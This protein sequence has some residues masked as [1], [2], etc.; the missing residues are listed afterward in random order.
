MSR[1]LICTANPELARQ[2][3]GIA[4]QAGLAVSQAARAPLA[5]KLMT[6]HQPELVLLDDQFEQNHAL[7]A[8]ANLLGLHGR[9]RIVLLL[10]QG[11]FELTRAALRLGIADMVLVPGEMDRLADLLGRLRHSAATR[12]SHTE[13]RC[14]AFFAAKGGAGCTTLAINTAVAC[15]GLLSGPVLLLDGNMQTGDVSAMLDVQWPRSVADL[16]PVLDEL[17]PG[18]IRD[19]CAAHE[20]GLYVLLAPPEPA[21]GHA[22]WPEQLARI[23]RVARRAFAAVVIDCPHPLDERCAA[24]LEEAGAPVLVST[25]DSPAVITWRRLRHLV[26]GS[27]ERARVVASQVTP[28]AEI[29]P[30]DL[31]G[32][33]GLPL[34]GEVRLDAATLAPLANT[35]RSLFE[36]P[37]GNG[38]AQRPAPVAQDVLRVTREL[39]G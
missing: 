35:G 16:L 38:R 27:M 19:V 33:V 14:I 24:L 34:A 28:K 29:S 3:A 22:L 15:T 12:T 17:T 20:S 9:T 8:A 13:G 31:A 1:A 2:L 32:L 6:E 36:Q 18:H 10:H 23:L 4:E 39:L 30:R 26:S 37:A 25:P 5:L 11:H 21:L 7:E